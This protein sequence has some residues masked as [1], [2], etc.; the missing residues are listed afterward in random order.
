MM[1]SES[2]SCFAASSDIDSSDMTVILR[3]NEL[4][5]HVS[6][7]CWIPWLHPRGGVGG[8]GGKHLR[9]MLVYLNTT[10]Q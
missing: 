8:G 4:L 1:A 2:L 9:L 3:L 6:V 5:G 7:P 10:Y